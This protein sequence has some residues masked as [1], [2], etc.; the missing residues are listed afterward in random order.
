M[1]WKTG[2]GPAGGEEVGAYLPQPRL[3]GAPAAGAEAGG[4]WEV[5]ADGGG[6]GPKLRGGEEEVPKP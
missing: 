2:E 6:A 5:R 1:G 3:A 4:P